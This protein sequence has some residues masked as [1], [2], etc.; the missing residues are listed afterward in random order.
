MHPVSGARCEL[1]TIQIVL[2]LGENVPLPVE[3]GLR[4]GAVYTQGLEDGWCRR[5]YIKVGKKDVYSS[6]LLRLLRVLLFFLL[7]SLSS[8][9]LPISFSSYIF[10]TFLQ[11]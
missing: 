5:R 10:F 9:T 1:T 4:R 8:S 2:F 3:P 6:P 11:Q 7:F